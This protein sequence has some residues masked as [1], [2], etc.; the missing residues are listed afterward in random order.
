MSQNFILSWEDIERDSLW[1]CEKIKKQN[2]DFKGIV[3]ISRGGLIPAG[4]ISRHLDI[5]LIE[6][7]SIVS[8]EGQEKKSLNILNELSISKQDL[9]EGWLV[10]D[11]LS[12]TGS[13]YSYLKEVLPKGT[14]VSLYSKPL[15]LD[16]VDIFSK[17]FPQDVWLVFPWE[18]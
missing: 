6:N 10:V 12:D 16:K 7:I 18:K 11:D 17:T 1:V 13:T 3:S 4:L 8:Y 2:K 5:T 9:G 15:G 14:F